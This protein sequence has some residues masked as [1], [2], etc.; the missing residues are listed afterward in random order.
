MIKPRHVVL[1]GT[2]GMHI[3]FWWEVLHVGGRIILKW[4][5]DKTGWSGMDWIHM[6]QDRD[7]CKA[8]VKTIMSLRVP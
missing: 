8:L 2:R 3:I 5:L 7:L 4:F 6:A 1:L